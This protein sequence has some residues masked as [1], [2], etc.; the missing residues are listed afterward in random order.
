M[1]SA[2]L[3]QTVRRETPR[4]V[5][6]SPGPTQA[7]MSEDSSHHRSDMPT[8]ARI[9]KRPSQLPRT[10]QRPICP[11]GD[12]GVSVSNAATGAQGLANL[13]PV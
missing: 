2:N 8:H 3:K 13:D 5:A 10:S 4:S 12:G 7:D 11:Q 9:P 1:D 6:S